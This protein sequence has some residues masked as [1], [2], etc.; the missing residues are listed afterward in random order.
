MQRAREATHAGTWYSDMRDQVRY[1]I[2]YWLAEV[3]DEDSLRSVPMPIRG[4]RTIIAPHAGY[5]YSGRCAAYAYKA[6]DLKGIERIFVLGPA[7]H[8]FY[9]TLALPGFSAYHTPLADEPLPLD[10]ELIEEF[11]NSEIEIGDRLRRFD[12]MTPGDDEDEHSIELHLPFIHRRLQLEY[13]GKPPSEYPPLVP[14]VVGAVDEETEEGFGAFL[15]PYLANPSNAFVI[16]SDFC[17]WGSRFRY[18]YY[19]STAPSPG[20]IIPVSDDLP[21]PGLEEDETTRLIE[22][23]QAGHALQPSDTLLTNPPIYASISALDLG[24]MAAI[25]TGSHGQFSKFI[26]DTNNTVCGRHPIGVAMAG[27]DKSGLLA[28]GLGRFHFIRYDRSSNVRQFRG[29]NDTSVSYA[30]AY[31]V[32]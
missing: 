5:A 19:A 27:I 20:P 14:I 12:T 29:G 1:Q 3:A 17:H 21:W 16:S 2:D 6:W 30:S 22:R 24:A 9:R 10:T 4:A 11:K 15:A 28:K 32:M 26:K 13:P 23:C 8:Q 7:H 18:T 25:S 31:A